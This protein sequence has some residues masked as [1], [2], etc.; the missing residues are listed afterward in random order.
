MNF[1]TT[2]SIVQKQVILGHTH[3][4]IQMILIIII[5]IIIITITIVCIDNNIVLYFIESKT[6][7]FFFTY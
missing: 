3:L 5:T 2:V 4:C 1:D 6:Y 7:F